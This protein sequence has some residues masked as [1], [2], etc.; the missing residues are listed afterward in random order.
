MCRDGQVCAAD[1]SAT[2]PYAPFTTRLFADLKVGT[3]EPFP[4]LAGKSILQDRRRDTRDRHHRHAWRNPVSRWPA[5]NE[6][7]HPPSTSEWCQV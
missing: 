4:V 2:R 5:G 7:R 3:S 1:A 6:S